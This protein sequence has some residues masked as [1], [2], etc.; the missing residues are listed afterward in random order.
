MEP[1]KI[2]GNVVWGYEE[3]NGISLYVDWSKANN[4]KSAFAGVIP[5]RSIRAYLRHKNPPK[6]YPGEKK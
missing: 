3:K 6:R 4:F 5:L 1:I 2:N